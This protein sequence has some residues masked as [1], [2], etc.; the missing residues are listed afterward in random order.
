MRSETD[1]F[2]KW[3]KSKEQEFMRLKSQDRKRLAQMTK[4]QT[5]YEKQKNT[6]R[7]KLEEAKAIEKRLKVIFLLNFYFINTIIGIS[8]PDSTSNFFYKNKVDT[9]NDIFLECFRFTKKSNSTA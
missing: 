9:T 8:L 2:N 3:K 7:R 5:E 4:L 1:K 6:Y